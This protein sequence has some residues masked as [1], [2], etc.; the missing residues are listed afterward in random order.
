MATE[1]TLAASSMASEKNETNSR[2]HPSRVAGRTE[3][4]ATV[5]PMATETV[6][7]WRLGALPAYPSQTNHHDAPVEPRPRRRRPL[8]APIQAELLVATET[9]ATSESMATN[10]KD[11][12]RLSISSSSVS[13]NYRDISTTNTRLFTRANTSR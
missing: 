4:R 11:N 9:T 13:S 8:S 1:S 12:F 5:E 7:R 10:R 3:T 2:R 6:V